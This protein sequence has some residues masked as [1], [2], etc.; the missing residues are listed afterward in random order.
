M[1]FYFCYDRPVSNFERIKSALD[2]SFLPGEESPL[3]SYVVPY[4]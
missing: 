2:E 3:T 1:V 4:G